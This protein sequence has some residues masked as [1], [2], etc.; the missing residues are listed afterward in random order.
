LT[1]SENPPEPDENF[2]PG[3]DE[4]IVVDPESL[5]KITFDVDRGTRYLPYIEF[6]GAHMIETPGVPKKT[7]VRLVDKS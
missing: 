7:P 3:I 4:P 6:K 5:F 2:L 1:I